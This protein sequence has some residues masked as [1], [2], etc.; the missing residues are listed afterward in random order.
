MKEVNC[1]NTY[2]IISLFPVDVQ[3]YLLLTKSQA[4]LFNDCLVD[5]V[6]ICF[7]HERA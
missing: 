5:V 4:H 1:S 2:M 6:A 7:T 3:L